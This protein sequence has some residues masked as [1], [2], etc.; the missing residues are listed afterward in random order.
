MIYQ[1]NAESGN[2]ALGGKEECP[3][4]A[5]DRVKILFYDDRTDR[6]K[7]KELTVMAII[8]CTDPYGTSN[9]QNRNI[10][11]DEK[12]FRSIYSGYEDYIG[13]ICF[14]SG[15]GGAENGASDSGTEKE[16]YEAVQKII[17]EEGNLQ[18]YFE[19]AYE[20]EIHFTTE[21]RVM[22][23]LGM[24]LAGI[25]GLI[26]IS[27]VVNT[28]ATDITARRLEYAAMQSIGM[29]KRQMRRDIFG[30]YARYV[31]CASGLAAAVGTAL[32]YVL[33][34]GSLFTGF[35]VGAF[36]PALAMLFFFAVF[37]CE[38]MACILTEAVN[39]QSVVER[40]RGI[41]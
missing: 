34:A 29:T 24:F 5:G 26:G 4:H 25:V 37:L 8:S 35:S 38:V 20:S 18:M 16:R 7:E 15:K 41:T 31:L 6:Y 1:R 3:V 32:T 12:T 36:L 21:K 33:G 9:I 11:L 19:S 17:E 23:M 2:M 10:I 27:N 30:R 13:R 39:R 14:D 22:G 28:V 40:L